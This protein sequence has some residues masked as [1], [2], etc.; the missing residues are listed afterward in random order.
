[1]SRQ[2][3]RALTHT[4]THTHTHIHS[5]TMEKFCLCVLCEARNNHK[6]SH[7]MISSLQFYYYRNLKSFLFQYYTVIKLI[8][9]LR[10][11]P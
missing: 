7:C 11:W 2:N 5:Q 3:A 9:S 1:V 4:H 10:H 6:P 8:I